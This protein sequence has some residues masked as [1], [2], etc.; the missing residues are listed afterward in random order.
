MEKQDVLSALSALAH[1]TRLDVFRLLVEAGP[2]GLAPG[3]IAD[4]LDIPAATLSFHLKELKSSG[5]VRRQRQGR[6]LLYAPDFTRM[7][8]LLAFLTVNCCR[9]ADC[10]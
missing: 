5:I 7:Q 6:S 2:A 1:E 8:E 4:R 3:G 10:G 9:S